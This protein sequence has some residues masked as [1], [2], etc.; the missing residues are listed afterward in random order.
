MAKLSNDFRVGDWEA[1]RQ[2]NQIVRGGQTRHLQ[3]RVMDVLYFLACHQG[4]VL[5]KDSIIQA[6]WVDSF[7]GDESLTYSLRELRRALDDDVHQPK[8]IETIPRRGYRLI[9][10]VEDMTQEPSE[11]YKI[12]GRIGEGA[13]GEVF[14]AEDHLLRRKVALKF[15]KP[16]LEDDKKARKSLLHEA[17]KAAALDHPAV[18]RTYDAG[19]LGG[20][21]FIALEYLEGE[22]VEQRNTSVRLSL[23]ESLMICRQVAEGLEHAHSHGIIH[24]DLKP[25]NLMLSKDGKVKILDF[26]LAKRVYLPLADADEGSRAAS[27][28]IS[29][30]LKGLTVGTAAYMSPEMIRGLEID[31]RTDVWGFGCLL[32]EL[33]ANRRA[34]DGTRTS[35]V[36]LKVLETEPDWAA[37]PQP[38]PARL[39]MLLHRC[40]QKDRE[41]RLRDA[42][43]AI[44]E[45]DEI[46]ATIQAGESR[47]PMV[48]AQLPA[49]DQDSQPVNAAIGACVD[50][51]EMEGVGSVHEEAGTEEVPAPSPSRGARTWTRPPRWLL[52]TVLVLAG[53]L[54][55]VFLGRVS[56][57][58]KPSDSRSRASAA[59]RIVPITSG[60]GLK[61][62]PTLSPDGSLVAFSS[63]LEGDSDICVTSLSGG[64]TARLTSD[65][66]PD[67][68]PSWSPDG[69]TIAF[70]RRYP[71]QRGRYQLMIMA[72]PFGGNERNLGDCTY[73]PSVSWDPSSKWVVVPFPAQTRGEAAGLFAVSTE[74]GERRRLTDGIADHRPVFSADGRS[75]AFVRNW[76]DIYVL[77]ISEGL[78][79]VG[80][81]RLLASGVLPEV[82]G[83]AWDPR[84]N[85]LV[86]SSESTGPGRLWRIPGEGG[87]ARDVPGGLS[88]VRGIAVTAGGNRLVLC[89][90]RTD[91]NIWRLPGPAVSPALDTPA[92]KLIAP[93]SRE[94]SPQYS[95][96]GNKIAFVSDRT[97]DWELW[98]ADWDGN[99][100]KPL[101]FQ[102]S[103]LV[104]EPSWSPDDSALA[105]SLHKSGETH[106]WL[107]PARGGSARQLTFE[108]PSQS[109][110]SWSRDGK[111]VY[112]SS[113]GNAVWKMAVKGAPDRRAVPVGVSGFQGRESLDGR[114]LYFANGE[115]GSPL[116][117]FRT[118]TLGGEA[119]PMGTRASSWSVWNHGVVFHDLF[120]SDLFSCAEPG[121]PTSFGKLPNSA[122]PF[123]NGVSVS[124]DGTWLVYV[125]T[126]T[127]E[128]D[129]VLIDGFPPASQ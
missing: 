83:M 8:Y 10:A 95:N 6:V 22:T 63:R 51:T 36:M 73:S 40:L 56:W 128:S 115:T 93:T 74:T 71:G 127:L 80:E 32:Y 53:L 69:R 86:C 100:Q 121:S 59:L 25:A 57:F 101:T 104:G 49:I 24:R 3:P 125:Q 15:L 110:P 61:E 106:I 78:S 12:L 21:T 111:H 5:S 123:S 88:H 97:G 99:N 28:S 38:L 89:R 7:V 52:L 107:V 58:S 45:I 26:G 119:E 14:K 44:L 67:F 124:P 94:L 126:D 117:I 37:L 112:F 41:R 62:G 77:T 19:E 118:S 64:A 50:T 96:D 35:E 91:T 48:D 75:L 66:A 23:I 11:R 2:L 79:P 76:K 84:D 65:P 30:D 70:L 46:V 13:I 129:L 105:F 47:S 27:I 1:H 116:D 108:K 54:G 39:D 18:C 9:A 31:R 33:L 60:P 81:P 17:R 34:F 43:D 68:A 20:R 113:P 109:S 82:L 114:W 42:G 55:A 4:E 102:K 16:E 120:T 103:G 92:R 90:D 98:V 29:L 87:G 72:A 85:S 122:L